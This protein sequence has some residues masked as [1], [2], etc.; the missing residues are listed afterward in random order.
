MDDTITKERAQLLI[1][2]FFEFSFNDREP[3]RKLFDL[4]T[5]PLELHFIADR[6]N[7]DDGAEVLS[8][9]INSRICD[10][11]TAKLI[12]WRSQPDFYTAFLNEQEADYEA[13]TYL[14]LRNI[15][16]NFEKGFYKSE[17]IAYDPRKD[18]GAPSNIDYRNPKEKWTIPE[19]LKTPNEGIEIQ[20]DV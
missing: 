10:K 19:Y 11:A 4:I 3:D 12:F 16:D 15:I 9:I 1:N 5:N 13:D 8:W 14:L 7:W 20:Y 2:N 18:P 6:Y 17:G